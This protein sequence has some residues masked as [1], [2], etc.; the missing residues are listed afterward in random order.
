MQPILGLTL[1]KRRNGVV[2]TVLAACLAATACT[3]NTPTI[4]GAPE[5]STEAA[6]PLTVTVSPDNG[7]GD[8]PASTEIGFKIG[9]GSLADVSVDADWRDAH[10]TWAKV[11]PR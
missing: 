11:T 6:N 10:H 1:A 5:Q 3:S 7:T 8:M 2:V 9:N 4:T